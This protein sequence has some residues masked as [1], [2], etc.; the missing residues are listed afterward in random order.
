[1]I[2]AFACGGAKDIP[3]FKKVIEE[4]DAHAAAAGSL[5]FY[6]GKQKAVLITVPNEQELINIGLYKGA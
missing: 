2:A 4:G 6:Y 5:Y 3:D 1:M